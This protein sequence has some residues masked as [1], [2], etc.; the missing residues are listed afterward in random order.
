MKH[1][2]CRESN[3]AFRIKNKTSYQLWAFSKEENEPS[4]ASKVASYL[5]KK[6]VATSTK[7]LAVSEMTSI[8]LNM[9]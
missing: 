3:L 8:Y 1:T 4:R 6:M 2:I 7:K 9:L 5:G